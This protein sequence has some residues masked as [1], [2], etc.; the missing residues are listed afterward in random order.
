M[1]EIK[2]DDDRWVQIQEKSEAGVRAL[3]MVKLH[4]PM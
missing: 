1:A 2:G 3:R 4:Q